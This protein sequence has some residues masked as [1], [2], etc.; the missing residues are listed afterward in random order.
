MKLWELAP[1]D[2]FTAHDG[3]LVALKTEYRHKIDS[4]KYKIAAYIV[5][6][7]ETFVPTDNDIE[8]EPFVP[9]NTLAKQEQEL[10]AA[11]RGGA[12]HYVLR[13]IADEYERLNT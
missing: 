6:S 10:I 3:R 12:M 13:L 2:L 11:W 4:D 9:E 1:G 5:G 8:V 7:G